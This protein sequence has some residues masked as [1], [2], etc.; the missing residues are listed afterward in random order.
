[1]SGI[2]VEEKMKTIRVLMVLPNLRVSNGV[3]NFA[4]N[5]FRG[6]DHQD[7]QIDFATLSYRDSPYLK[8]VMDKGAK[9]FILPSIIRHPLRHIKECR[10][11]INTG[12]YNVVHINTLNQAIPILLVAKNCVKVRIFHSHSTKIGE[13]RLKERINGMFLPILK[14]LTNYY[15]ACSSNAGRNLFGGKSFTIIPNL[16]DTDHFKYN[17]EKRTKIRNRENVSG[18][19][20]VGSVGRLAEPKNP[21]FAIEVAKKIFVQRNDIVYWWIGS[22]PLDVSIKRYIEE[23][24]LTDKIKIFGS[25][26]DI[27]D[28]YQAMDAF[29]L[30]SLFEGFGLAC[31]EAQAA[32]LPCTVSCAFPSEVNITGNVQFIS[33]DQT[34]GTWAQTVIS[35]LDKKIDKDA[36]NR[37]C[38]ESIYSIRNSSRLLTQYYYNCVEVDK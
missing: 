17:E 37:M 33:L 32:G 2:N 19:K 6:V 28:L 20:V 24:N 10:K 16:I 14:R 29:L 21:F 8:E 38:V 27:I 31:L 5:Y 3:T 26:D 23:E 22:G 25:R 13:T 35:S 1:M 34:I 15:L 30:P 7:I 9:V 4:M 18:L 12:N 36:A 11:I